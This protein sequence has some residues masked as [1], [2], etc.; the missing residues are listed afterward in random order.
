MVDLDYKFWLQILI[1]AITFGIT[2]GKISTELKWMKE[3]LDRH[4]SFQDRV[5]VVEQSTKSIH[6][7]MDEL[8]TKVEDVCQRILYRNFN[9]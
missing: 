8:C 4:N 6:H 7:R 2:F 9:E 1:Y 5:V 3:K